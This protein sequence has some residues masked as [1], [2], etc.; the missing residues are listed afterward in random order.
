MLRRW[1]E[2][3]RVSNGDEI[4]ALFCKLN[5]RIS[6]INEHLVV[7]HSYFML[8]E[9]AQDNSPSGPYPAHRLEEIWQ[10]SIMPL[11]AEYQPHLSSND[12][13]KVYGLTT[14]KRELPT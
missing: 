6:E 13:E 10:F 12:L 7:G 5:E 9:L 3:N 1:L 4:V 8:P 11:L 2:T 14:L